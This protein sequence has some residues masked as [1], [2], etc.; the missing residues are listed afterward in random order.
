MGILML[1]SKT[2]TIE[3][4]FPLICICCFFSLVFHYNVRY[5]YPFFR[6]YPFN[7][8]YPSFFSDCLIFLSLHLFRSLGWCD[9]IFLSSFF[10][11]FCLTWLIE[12]GKGLK[13]ELFP[14]QE[15]WWRHKVNKELVFEPLPFLITRME[16][17]FPRMSRSFLF[18][19]PK[20]ISP[21]FP[22]SPLHSPAHGRTDRESISAFSN[23]T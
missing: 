18:Q 8:V 14:E 9:V 7:R 23:V 20:K 6:L 15:R 21:S 17:Y 13:E 22:K 11:N 5:F 12:D 10:F 19:E 3:L 2:F 16:N 1:S 4:S